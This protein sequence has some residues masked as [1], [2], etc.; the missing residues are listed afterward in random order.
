[1]GNV[2]DLCFKDINLE[3]RTIM[4]YRNSEVTRF[5]Y[6]Q[7]LKRFM[8]FYT[9]VHVNL[10]SNKDREDVFDAALSKFIKD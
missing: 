3:G 7:W 5:N 10:N 1:M 2:K 4:E 8:D 9:K 6:Q